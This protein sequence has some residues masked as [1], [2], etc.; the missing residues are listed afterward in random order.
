MIQTKK[1]KYY[2]QVLIYIIKKQIKM[3]KMQILTKK[4]VE[5]KVLIKENLSILT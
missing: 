3:I 1:I 4:I 2:I 5:M